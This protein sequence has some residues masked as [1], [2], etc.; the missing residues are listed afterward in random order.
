MRPAVE[1]MAHLCDPLKNIEPVA[2][3]LSDPVSFGVR[4]SQRIGID[5]TSAGAAPAKLKTDGL[6]LR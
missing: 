5:S 4:E 2:S 3:P 6:G 1:D